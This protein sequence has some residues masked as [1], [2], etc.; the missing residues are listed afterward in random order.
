MAYP[1]LKFVYNWADSEWI[2]VEIDDTKKNYFWPR[3]EAED[4][5]GNIR[6]Y[7][8]KEW[9][10][11]SVSYTFD[12]FFN[13]YWADYYKNPKELKECYLWHFE[14]H[15]TEALFRVATSFLSYSPIWEDYDEISW[16][17]A[18]L[19]SAKKDVDVDSLVEKWNSNILDGIKH[20]LECYYKYRDYENEYEQGDYYID[21]V[22]SDIK[23]YRDFNK[24]KY[25]NF[26][27]KNFIESKKEEDIKG[28]IDFVVNWEGYFN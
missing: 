5:D 18:C 9:D 24:V 16:Y 23:A 21:R 3:M 13:E 15:I 14:D 6:S 4:L 1:W 12:D 17:K 2:Y 25:K 28:I 26:N 8:E 20:N 22:V 19:R 11:R 10:S 27:V 7:R